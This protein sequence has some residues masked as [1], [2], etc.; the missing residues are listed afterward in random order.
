MQQ[1]ALT[2]LIDDQLMRD[3]LRKKGPATDQQE[4]NRQMTELVEGLKKDKK[5]LE[6]FLK[7]QNQTEAQL[8][9][10]ITGWLQWN[11]F[12]KQQVTDAEL[13]KYYDESKDF[14]D[15]VVVRAS[16]I[17]LRVSPNASE[18]ERK[19]VK[20]KLQGWRQE[21]TE[22]KV[23]FVKAAKDHSQCTSAPNGGDIGFFPRKLAVEEPFAKAAFALKVGDISDVV[24]TDFGYHLIK[25]TDRKAGTPSEFNKIKEEVREL[26]VEELRVLILAEQR[27]TAKVEVNL[28]QS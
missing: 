21:I 6:D 12:V 15:R 2:M 22:G 11:A 18:D 16:H 26:F 9:A 19:A 5:S 23:D 17:V 28:P 27:Q 24:Q 8:R 7:E 3:F 4:V 25:V 1:E 10:D 13:K 20:A 14:F